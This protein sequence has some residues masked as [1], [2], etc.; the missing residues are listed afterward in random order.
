M[1]PIKLVKASIFTALAIGSGYAL[2]MV[3]NVELISVIIFVSGI[4]LGVGW[5]VVIGCTAEFIFSV[6]NPL[7]SGLVFPPLLLTQVVGM[8]LVGLAGGLLR[9]YFINWNNSLV[10]RIL[11]VLTGF[12]LTFIFDSLTTLSYP[13]SAGFDWPQIKALYLTGIGFTTLHMLSNSIIY[14]FG[15]PFILNSQVFRSEQ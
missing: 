14:A 6:L 5:G 15:V 11:L 10:G 8:G 7:G 3:P 13:F 12:S 4:W 9:P 2:M 1:P